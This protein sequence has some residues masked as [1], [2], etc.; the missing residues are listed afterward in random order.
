MNFAEALRAPKL[1]QMWPWIWSALP[2]LVLLE[3]QAVAPVGHWGLLILELPYVL[4]I[5]AAACCILVLPF[6]ALRRARR[7][8]ALAW[9]VAA[10][11]YLSLAIGGLVIGE[12][13]RFWAFD[14]LAERSVPLVSAIRSY[15]TARG[16]PPPTLEALVPTFLPRVPRTG[17]MAYPDYQY[18]VGPDAQRHDGNPWA[19]VVFTPGGGINFDRFM[20]FPLQNYPEIGYGGPLARI[21]DWAYVHE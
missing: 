17:M 3:Y 9:L 6:V 16:Q 20:Y 11:L 13:I 14:R 10:V 15:E 21:R 8:S 5:L 18:Y 4:G 19:L 7:L 1:R 2:V 12:R